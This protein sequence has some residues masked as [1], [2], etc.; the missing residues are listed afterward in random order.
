M[1]RRQFI[2][3][4]A[5]AAVW[6]RA[7]RAQKPE[8]PTVGFLSGASPK[9]YARNVA[10]FLGGLKEANHVVGQNLAIEYRWAEGQYD[11]LPRMAADLANRRVAVIVANTPA[12]PAAKTA[13]TKIPIVFLTSEDPVQIGLVS[14]LNQ[15]GGN[16][17]GVS[18]ISSALGGKQLGV[19]RELVPAARSVGYLVNP[20][21]PNSE[22]SVRNTQEGAIALGLKMRILTAAT[23]SEIDEAFRVQIDALAIAPDSFFIS[24]TDQLVALAARHALPTVYPFR[25][26]SEAGGLLSYG[27][28]VPDLYRQVGVYTGKILQGA[29]PAEMPVLQPTKFE[30]VINLKTAKA[31]KVAIPSGVMA[32]ADDVIE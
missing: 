16:V 3:F 30:L 26:F 12:A 2:S 31:L 25:E 5:G 27:A 24:R 7:A 28:S 15:P 17:T 29:K 10:A 13:T 21:N 9:A 20:T 23:E 6:P 1:R 32:I 11:L 14:S 22:N 4:L 18:V 8:T 19:L